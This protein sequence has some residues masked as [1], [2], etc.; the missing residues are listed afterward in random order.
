MTRRGTKLHEKS[1][2]YQIVMFMVIVNYIEDISELF[3]D[4][5]VK[6][7]CHQHS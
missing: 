2:L 5:N 7:K 1:N 3:C 4:N 6:K